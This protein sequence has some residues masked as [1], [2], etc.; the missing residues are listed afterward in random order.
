MN[1]KNVIFSSGPMFISKSNISVTILTF[2]WLGVLESINVRKTTYP[3]RHDYVSFYS[4]YR[5]VEP[6][7]MQ[8]QG[9]LEQLILKKAD[10][11][12]GNIII[13][14]DILFKNF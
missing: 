6:H 1:P 3:Y 7:F 5:E 14:L 2:T 9:S 4:S 13:M 11:K 8:K 10:F 12:F